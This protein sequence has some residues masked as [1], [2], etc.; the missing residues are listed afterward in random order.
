MITAR[1]HVLRSSSFIPLTRTPVHPLSWLH[2]FDP[3]A[4]IGVQRDLCK[5]A[6]Y[7]RGT[8]RR[9]AARACGQAVAGVPGESGSGD[10]CRASVILARAQR[11]DVR[12]NSWA[13]LRSDSGLPASTLSRYAATAASLT[14]PASATAS[15]RGPPAGMVGRP[16][17]RSVGWRAWPG[18]PRSLRLYCSLSTAAAGAEPATARQTAP[19]RRCSADGPGP[20][21]PEMRMS[22]TRSSFSRC[23]KRA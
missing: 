18:T 5:T 7:A 22:Q 12:P 3:A 14:A 4:C 17:T 2:A 19:S 8:V 15:S 1:Y 6:D 11:R 16:A 20:A 13:S 9:D 10:A 21:V 23:A